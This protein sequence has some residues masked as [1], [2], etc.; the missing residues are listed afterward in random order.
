[1]EHRNHFAMIGAML[2]L[3]SVLARVG[4]HLKLRLRARAVGCAVLLSALCGVTALRAYDW[5]SEAHFATNSTLL[6]PRSDRAWFA[7]CMYEFNAGG[8]AVATNTN[9]DKAIAACSDGAQE[10]PYALNSLTTLIVLK[11]MR[12][13][14][15]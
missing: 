12:G 15:Q 4:S 13:D 1:F 8:E 3:G 14:I 7:L 5:K 9:L 2:A 6:A 10:A 11:T